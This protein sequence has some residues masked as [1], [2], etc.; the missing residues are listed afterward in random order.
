MV[1]RDG[2][3]GR[4]LVSKRGHY[5]E[6]SFSPDGKRIVYRHTGGDD[7]RGEGFGAGAG[8]YVSDVEGGDPRLVRERGVEPRLDAKGERIYFRERRGDKFVLASVKLDGSDEIVHFESENATSMLTLSPG[9]QPPVATTWK[10]EPAAPVAGETRRSFVCAEAVPWKN[11][12]A[13]TNATAHI[14]AIRNTTTPFLRPAAADVSTR[15][16]LSRCAR[17]LT[18]LGGSDRLAAEPLKD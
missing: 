12:H 16:S 5:T 4:E 6:L 17:E 11:A 15:G 3:G 13:I 2:G 7:V 18:R 1:G 9:S 8:I 14:P 10:R